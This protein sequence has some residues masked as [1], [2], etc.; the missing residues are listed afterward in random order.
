M[1]ESNEE[2]FCRASGVAMQDAFT[3]ISPKYMAKKMNKEDR[4][5]FQTAIEEILKI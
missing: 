3:G 4:N 1:K 2:N 5:N